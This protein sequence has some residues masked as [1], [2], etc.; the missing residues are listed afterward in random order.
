MTKKILIKNIGLITVLILFSFTNS[1]IIQNVK[2][3]TAYDDNIIMKIYGG[4]GYTFVVTNHKEYCVNGSFNLTDAKGIIVDKEKFKVYP[5]NE[6]GVHTTIPF[7]HPLTV[8]DR[9]NAELSVD[10]Q[11]LRKT[12]IKIWIFFFFK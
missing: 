2:S 12:G 8:I 4:I 7:T 6:F 3:G 10:N 11:T 5:N 1:V 9:V